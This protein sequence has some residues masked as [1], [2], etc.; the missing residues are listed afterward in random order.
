MFT[1]LKGLLQCEMFRATCLAKVEPN[2]TY[3]NGSSNLS[4]NDFGRCKVCYTV[5]VSCNLSRHSVAKTLRDKLHETFHS[6]TYPAMAK[7]VARQVARKVEPN[8]TYGNGSSNLSRNDFGRCRVSYTVKCFVQLVPPQCRQNIARQVARNI[9]QRRCY[10]VQFFMQ[11]VSQRI[12]IQ[13][14]RI[15]VKYCATAKDR[16]RCGK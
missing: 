10:N 1:P 9:S 2:S 5:N 15:I 4:R 6:V 12:A 7:I 14:S 13:V 11:L 16:N 3:G 8:S